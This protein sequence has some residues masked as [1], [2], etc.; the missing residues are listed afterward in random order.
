MKQ[1]EVID[2][3]KVYQE[4]SLKIH[5]VKGV[6]LYIIGPSGSGKTTLLSVIECILKPTQDHV[7]ITGEEITNWDE[8][9]L[10]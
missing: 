5:A 9:S 4:G 6:T 7:R 1:I 3:R 2:V 8:N 10:L